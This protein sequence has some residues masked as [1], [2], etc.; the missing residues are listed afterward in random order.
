MRQKKDIYEVVFEPVS[1][2]W[3]L[4]IGIIGIDKTLK[5]MRLTG[6]TPLELE[7]LFRPLPCE[8]ISYEEKKKLPWRKI[9]DDPFYSSDLNRK[10]KLSQEL[11][12]WIKFLKSAE[13]KKKRKLTQDEWDSLA[14]EWMELYEFYPGKEHWDEVAESFELDE[15][16]KKQKGKRDKFSKHRK[17]LFDWRLNKETFNLIKSEGVG[18]D[19]NKFNKIQIHS[20]LLWDEIQ[21]IYHNPEDLERVIGTLPKSVSKFIIQGGD[22]WRKT[23]EKLSLINKESVEI[24]KNRKLRIENEIKRTKELLKIHDEKRIKII[25]RLAVMTKD[26]K[27]WGKLITK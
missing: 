21:D 7:Q 6:L 19:S 10:V 24:L 11:N 17:P 18:F 13:L 26:L 5:L 22:S 12:P 8:H 9:Y 25:A 27:K 15:K 4:E 3:L 2:D 23:S 1:K 14:Q 16:N 20:F